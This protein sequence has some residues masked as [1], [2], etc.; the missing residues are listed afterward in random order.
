MAQPPKSWYRE[1]YVWLVVGGPL[2][3]VLASLVTVYLAVKHQDPV[4]KGGVPPRSTPANSD[5][6]SVEEQRE[7]VERSNLPAGVARN[8]V[9]S[10]SLPKDR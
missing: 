10:P 3:V 9:V 6:L 8:H 2:L 7:A 1:P 5:G 4:L